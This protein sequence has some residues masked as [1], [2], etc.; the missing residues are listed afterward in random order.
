MKD[1]EIERIRKRREAQAEGE[2]TRKIITR[3]KRR[4]E[5]DRE[6]NGGTEGKKEYRG[7]TKLNKTKL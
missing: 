3:R 1:K 2:G 6:E 7:E 5:K 4:G